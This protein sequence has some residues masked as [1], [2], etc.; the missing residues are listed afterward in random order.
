[1]Q[2]EKQD[3]EGSRSRTF[4]RNSK[5]RGSWARRRN[6]E[7]RK[8]SRRAQEEPTAGEQQDVE[9]EQQKETR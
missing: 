7:G 5:S 1:V 8:T 9:Q 3:V 2:E 4:R 6:Q